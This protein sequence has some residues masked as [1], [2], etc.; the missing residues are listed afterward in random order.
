MTLPRRFSVL[1]SLRFV[2]VLAVISGLSVAGWRVGASESVKTKA[3]QLKQQSR[4]Y[5]NHVM[6]RTLSPMVAAPAV[7]VATNVTSS[8]GSSTAIANRQPA[9]A[10]RWL[11]A[12]GA[13]VNGNSV[14]FPPSSNTGGG[15]GSTDQTPYLGE[16]RLLAFDTASD[17]VPAGWYE[18]DGRSLPINQNLA[19]FSLLGT[20]Y[21]GNGTTT[22][23]LPDMRGRVPVGT[24]QGTGLTN[25]AR[26]QFGA[27][28]AT[29]PAHTHTITGGTTASAGS[30]TALINKQPSVGLLMGIVASGDDSS[31][32]TVRLFAGSYYPP[33]FVACDG[34]SL[35]TAT[36][37]ALF[38]KIGYTYGGSGAN[39]NVPDLR[40]RTPIG[41][42]QGTGLTNRTLGQQVG[43][44]IPTVTASD[45]P[46]HTHTYPGGTTGSVGNAS[47]SSFST[48][49]PSLVLRPAMTL[50]GTFNSFGVTNSPSAAYTEVRFFAFSSA[51]P[52]NGGNELWV[53]CDGS[54]HA[55]D[56]F[57]GNYD[58]YNYTFIVGT[59][60][61]GDGEN[62][63]G[64]PD[65]R[66][67]AV[68]S[69]GTSAG[70]TTRNVG[71]KF[72]AESA[73]ALTV[74]NLPAHTHDLP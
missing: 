34:R 36:F 59:I 1:R 57:N 15:T 60:Y 28:A 67:R 22:F 71:D 63:S 44:E 4:A 10:M 35:S 8:T 20:T 69:R 52:T 23:N 47:Q 21:G 58:F 42:G 56:E 31:I 40:G 49:Q 29:L 48:M 33:G 16:L 43:V 32:G 73:A 12:W 45:M 13:Q 41:R 70:L 11:I 61:G 65:L 7:A 50:Y 25:V 30:G 6:P 51:L 9:L 74:A 72:G 64:V 38:A 2:F 17:N 18:C 37:S 27:E 14:V 53:E 46:A 62:T 26:G 24:G 5:L 54:V 66:G 3:A 68:V 55:I 19:L 39:F